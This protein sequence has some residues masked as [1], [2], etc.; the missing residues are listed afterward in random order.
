MAYDWRPTGSR[1]VTTGSSPVVAPPTAV[2]MAAAIEDFIEAAEQGSAVNRSGRRYR[3]SALRDVKGILRFHVAPALGERPVNEVR[4][5]DIQALVDSLRRERLSESR[6]RSVISALRALYAYAID[7]RYVEFNPADSLT[8]P[9]IPEDDPSIPEDDPSEDDGAPPRGGD[10]DE[11]RPIAVL[12]ERL[13][14][15]A[16]RAALVVFAIVAIL[17]IVQPA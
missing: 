11:Y 6:I 10:T 8:M 2:T 1:S 17:S 3:P 14:S 7:M 4:R 13:L 12:P 5:A 9:A 16:L 15:L